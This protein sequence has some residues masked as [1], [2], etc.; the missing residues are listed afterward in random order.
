MFT[1]LIHH[2]GTIQR[3]QQQGDVRM[4]IKPDARDFPLAI[5]ASIAC[6]GICLTV[7]E[8][9]ADG[10]FVATLSQETL[11]CTTARL[12]KNGDRIH[13]EPSLKVGDEVGGHF[14]SGHVDGV[15]TVVERKTS[16]ASTV[17]T[18]EAPTELA[19]FIAAKG[20]VT[21]NGV[22]LTVNQ[23]EGNRFTVNV[24]PHTA[25]VTCFGDMEVGDRVN[26]EVDLL[27]RYVARM[28]EMRA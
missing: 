28:I 1:G 7:V 14:V 18:F 26:L 16:G 3:I 24:I 25:D 27:A 23:T 21:L 6:H 12:W 22:S 10:A 4:E 11:N 13:L 15:T 5:G 9:L 19:P 8:M 17:W 20:S 2:L